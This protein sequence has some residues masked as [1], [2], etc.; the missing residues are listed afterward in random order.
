MVIEENLPDVLHQFDKIIAETPDPP[1][2][3]W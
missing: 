3:K 2:K 1:M